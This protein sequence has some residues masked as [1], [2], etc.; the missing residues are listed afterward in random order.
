MKILYLQN[1]PINNLNALASWIKDNN[2]IV[3]GCILCN[4]ETLPNTFDFDVL[5]IL[6]GNPAECPWLCHEIRYI[7]EAIRR[8]KYV[9]GICLGCQLI[10]EALGGKL[11]P[12]KYTE[13]GWWPVQFKGEMQKHVLLRGLPTYLNVFLY[14]QNT[15][16]FPNTLSDIEI[17]GN[18]QGC[19][20]Q[21][22]LYKENVL[23]IQFH[24]EFTIKTLELQKT[25]WKA[26]NGRYIQPPECWILNNY[27]NIA[28]KFI[29]TIMKNISMLTKKT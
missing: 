1:H 6:G 15:F 13:I 4:G 14:H 5:L 16:V 26:V 8:K 7:E 24:P 20:K 25:Y 18:S 17:L 21:M 27:C 29:Y 12:H 11:V 2:H 9:I 28:N 22:F 23:G 19:T 10:A 3:E